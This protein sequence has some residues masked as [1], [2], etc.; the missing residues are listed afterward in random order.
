MRDGYRIVYNAH[1]KK[2]KVQHKILFWWSD[3]MFRRGFGDF[4]TKLYETEKEAMD[5]IES[6]F[7]PDEWEVTQT[8][9]YEWT[10]H[11]DRDQKELRPKVGKK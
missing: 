6:C 4:Y 10:Y 3:V 1:I 5:Y 7:T 11:P 2:Y 9:E 8:S